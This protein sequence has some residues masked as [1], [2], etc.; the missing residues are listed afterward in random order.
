[1]TKQISGDEAILWGAK[2]ANFGYISSYPDIMTKERLNKYYNIFSSQAPIIQ[3]NRNGRNAFEQ[4]IGA[5]LGGA[6]ILIYLKAP[7]FISLIDTII[8][9]SLKSTKLGSFVIAIVDAPSRNDDYQMDPR[10]FFPLMNIPLLEPANPLEGFEMTYEAFSI[11]ECYQIPVALRLRTGFQAMDQTIELNENNDDENI[12]IDYNKT[13]HLELCDCNHDRKIQQISMIFEQ[14][15]FNKL[16]GNGDLRLIVS[17][18]LYQKLRSVIGNSLDKRYL[19][20][21]LGTI[22][23][24][25][26]MMIKQLL[27]ESDSALILEDGEPVIENEIHDI[28]NKYKLNTRIFANPKN[29]F[30]NLK[31]MKKWELEEIINK[32]D[33]EYKSDA[34]F[35]PY[36]EKT[37]SLVNLPIC[38]GC[39]FHKLFISLKDFITHLKR[40]KPLII[41]DRGCPALLDEEPYNLLDI[42]NPPGSAIA[43]ATGMAKHKPNRKF[44]VVTDNDSFFK[45]GINAF[46][47]ARQADVNV[48]IIILD[49]FG[50][51]IVTCYKKTSDT[52]T[53]NSQQSSKLTLQQII[54]S[55]SIRHVYS[56]EVEDFSDLKETF[57]TAYEYKGMSVLIV[58]ANCIIKNINYES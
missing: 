17:G 18:Y 22:Y 23:P 12:K 2:K 40:K 50:D 58:K 35:F 43:I 41:G 56:F 27:R 33:P 48:M 39:D 4:A 49:K 36:K 3:L 53:F 5:S 37:S 46:L 34:V 25:P 14:S 55:Y 10:K 45:D 29:H 52:N 30:S 15:P 11:S 51:E 1:M 20:L 26:E 28:V 57:Y 47:A 24:L 13:P 42:A 31:E 19:V 32:Y 8:S 38:A 7:D 21:K 44:I 9:I 54:E 6:K 16:I